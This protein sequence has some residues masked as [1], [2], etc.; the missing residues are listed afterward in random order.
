MDNKNNIP[1]S[2]E[3]T[4]PDN[5]K[6]FRRSLFFFWGLGL[7]WFANLVLLPYMARHLPHTS[8]TTAYFLSVPVTLVIWLLTGLCINAWKCPKCKKR[9]SSPGWGRWFRGVARV[10]ATE[11]VFKKNAFSGLL[12]HN[13]V[14][15]A[16]RLAVSQPEDEDPKQ[17]KGTYD[18]SHC[19]HCGL[20]KRAP[21]QLG[22]DPAQYE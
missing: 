19:V 4:Y 1:E 9:F 20:M 13:I 6:K 2:W 5:W 11:A 8:L 16:S 7:Y 22:T 21:I 15:E 3:G 12:A 14:S 17:Y 10:A 18:T